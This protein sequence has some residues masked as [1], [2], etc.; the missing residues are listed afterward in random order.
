MSEQYDPVL[1]AVSLLKRKRPIERLA[2]ARL[3]DVDGPPLRVLHWLVDQPDCDLATAAMVLWRLRGLR[4]QRVEPAHAITDRIPIAELIVARAGRGGCVNQSFAWDGLEAWDGFPLMAASKPGGFTLPDAAIPQAL[5]GPF[6]GQQPEPAFNALL[7]DDEDR[8]ISETLWR[9]PPIYAAAADW[10]IGKPANVWMAAVDDLSGRHPE[11][12]F[13]WM[14]RRP[15]CPSSVAGQIFW[16]WSGGGEDVTSAMLEGHEE[17]PDPV[18][19]LVLDRW[20]KG[21]LAD[22]RLDFSGFASAAAIQAALD[23]LRENPAL[24]RFAGL[25]APVQGEPIAPVRLFDDFDYFCFAVDLGGSLPRPRQAAIGAWEAAR[26]QGETYPYRP[27]AESD[28]A[29]HTG[30]LDR[31]WYGGPFTGYQV[32]VDRGWKRFNI[33][34]IAGAALFIA[35]WRIGAPKWAFAAFLAWLALVI[36]YFTTATTGGARRSAAWWTAAAT[37]SIALAFLFR[38]IDKGLG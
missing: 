16:R 38:Y 14:L 11:D 4:P 13:E 37:L 15:E 31:F 20:R 10:L 19:A 26:K 17:H 32:Q 30:L 1:D 12:I 27:R 33:A 36:L 2:I 25:L 3:L 21:D 28:D 6:R 9:C 35:L 18:I 29:A 8:A 24:E 34:S 23:R 5:H 7:D 22:C